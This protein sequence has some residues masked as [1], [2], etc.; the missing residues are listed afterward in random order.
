MEKWYNTIINPFKAKKKK[1]INSVETI[2]NVLAIIE[3][4]DVLF[5][6]NQENEMNI[7]THTLLVVILNWN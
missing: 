7:K 1:Q 3:V 4:I 6:F 2:I 5:P